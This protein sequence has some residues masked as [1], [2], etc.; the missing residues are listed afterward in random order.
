MEYHTVI[1]AYIDYLGF[2]NLV[3]STEEPD[4]IHKK[5][6]DFVRPLHDRGGIHEWYKLDDL[7][8]MEKEEIKEE[9]ELEDEDIADEYPRSTEFYFFS[10]TVIRM[11]DVETF[12]E[13]DIARAFKEEVVFLIQALLRQLRNNLLVRGIIIIGK[14]YHS[15]KVFFGPALTQAHL[16][17]K[18][19]V[20]YPRICIDN[21]ITKKIFFDDNKSY[22][23]RILSTML[24]QDF[25]GMFFID[26]L[27]YVCLEFLDSVKRIHSEHFKRY[28]SQN[29]LFR[30]T[31][32]NIEDEIKCSQLYLE[33]E[34]I[35]TF[36]NSKKT[37]EQNLKNIKE[38]YFEKIFWLRNYHNRTLRKFGNELKE[39]SNININ[40]FIINE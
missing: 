17:E 34:V 24:T 3:H 29:Y 13:K 28:M 33:E 9:M 31:E 27:K 38:E 6:N 2:K 30:H 12:S 14:S 8:K 26:Y 4:K 40:D 20:I 5:I 36:T 37:I 25:D 15:E 21:E 1:L 32:G 39:K 19:K 22:N 11:K 7:E 23:K 16:I 10:D 35:E 18:N